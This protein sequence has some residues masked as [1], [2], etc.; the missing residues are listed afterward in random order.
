MP[1]NIID[2]IWNA[3]TVHTEK[4]APDI[5]FLDLQLLH[6]VTSPQAFSELRKSGKKVFD[7]TRNIATLDHSIPTNP[8]RDDFAEESNKIQL[9]THR[10]NCEEFGIHLYDIN[11]GHQGVVHV[12]GPELGLTQPGMT[13][14]CGDSHT[15]THGAFGALAFGVGT[16]QIFHVLS[17]SCLLMEKPKTM[18]VNFVGTPSPYFTAKDAILALIRHI[19][20]QGGTGYALEYCG[21]FIKNCSMEERMTICNM[22]IECGARAG[23]IAPD[24]TTF[25][26]LKNTG[27]IPTEKWNSAVQNWKNYAS[28]ENAEY[29]KTITIDITNMKPVITWGTTPGQSV[30]INEH[31]PFPEEIPEHERDLAQKSLAYTDL[32]AGQAIKGVPVQHVFLGS[33]TNGRLSDLRISAKIID[34]KKVADGVRFFVVPGSEQVEKQAIAEGLDKIFIAAGADFRR[35]GCSMCL[36][37]NGDQVPARERCISTS[38]RNFMGRQGPDSITHLASPIMATIAAITGKITDPEAYFA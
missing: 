13:I 38:N 36:A 34:G 32:S 11:S 12:T 9:E 35:P 7:P 15:S 31:I 2:K 30:C 28:D 4:G 5:L 1:Q 14:C 3:H 8:T 17:S 37:M 22:S 10:K 19:G 27:K 33:C 21:E 6:E 24:E 29:E 18:R 20:V 16:T 26:W 23:L 25:G